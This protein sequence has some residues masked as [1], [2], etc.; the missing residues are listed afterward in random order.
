MDDKSLKNLKSKFDTIRGNTDYQMDGIRELY[1]HEY[2]CTAYINKI[3]ETS[4]A[5]KQVKVKTRKHVDES[6]PWKD[7]DV[8]VLASSMPIVGA[9]KRWKWPLEI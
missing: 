3:K 2:D 6:L 1:W 8:N 7:H 9:K 4:D 5:P